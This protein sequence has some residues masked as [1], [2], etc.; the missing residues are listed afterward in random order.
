MAKDTQHDDAQSREDG[1]PNVVSRRT[2]LKATAASSAVV[3]MAGQAGAQEEDVLQ[4]YELVGERSGWVGKSPSDIEDVENPTLDVVPDETF[5]VKWENGDGMPHNFNIQNGHGQ[6]VESSSL[7]SEEGA[8]QTVTFTAAS[9]FDQYYC[10]PHPDAMRG[11][12]RVVEE[13]GGGESGAYTLTVTV[14]NAAGEA[15]SG[16]VTV[17]G[18]DKET[19]TDSP[20]VTYALSEGEYT[21][22]VE[23]QSYPTATEQ[24][25]IDGSDAETTVTVASDS[26]A[27]L[28]LGQQTSNGRS[29]TVESVT[30]P[31]GGFVSVQDP[32]NFSTDGS[33]ETDP[34]NQ[35][36]ESFFTKTILGV[37][38]YLEAGSHESVQIELDRSF[39]QSTRLLAMAH[40][41]TGAGESFD[42][43]S[44]LGE[45]DAGY[46]FM[47]TN[48]VVGEAMMEYTE[49]TPTPTEEPSPTP[50][51]ES[52]PTPSEEPTTTEGPGFGGLTG[53]AGLG[54]GAAA[55]ARRFSSSD[56][57]TE[58]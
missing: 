42:Y 5:R 58:E 26:D 37:S 23:T 27:Y 40:E 15:V 32:T 31:D 49:P 30:L 13:L 51:E 18:T 38:D 2:V 11:D 14:Q 36:L 10:A 44:S 35:N 48:P 25:T 29:V 19:S 33:D 24:V 28:T 56:E 17:D 46:S 53:I 39:E 47:G 57:E 45:E 6:N 22:T 7:V 12:F 52:T 21:V 8:T 9:N 41:D 16:T 1:E 55:V 4:T 50:T 3:T 34:L 54:A 43:A 20:S